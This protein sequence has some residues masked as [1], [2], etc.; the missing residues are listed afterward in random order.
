MSNAT[1]KLKK[2]NWVWFS[3]PQSIDNEVPSVTAILETIIAIPLYWYIATSVGIFWPLAL[4]AVVVAPLVLLRSKHSTV[5]G[6]RWFDR[7]YMAHSNDYFSDPYTAIKYSVW[8]LIV[9][10]AISALIS[11][12]ILIISPS[13]MFIFPNLSGVSLYQLYVHFRDSKSRRLTL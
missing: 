7:I 2:P 3:T 5:R 13:M 11:L 9:L 8:F 4:S 1:A 10:S 12:Y 6:L